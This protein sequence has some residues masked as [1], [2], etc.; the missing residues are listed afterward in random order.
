MNRSARRRVRQTRFANIVIIT[1][2]IIISVD[3]VCEVEQIE[4]VSTHAARSILRPLYGSTNWTAIIRRTIV[5]AIIGYRVSA[6][7]ERHYFVY[8][9]PCEE[10]KTGLRSVH[11]FRTTLHAWYLLINRNF[12][13]KVFVFTDKRAF[14]FTR[15]IRGLSVDIVGEIIWYNK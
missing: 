2:I 6:K 1:I 11:V 9:K 10:N 13:T 5:A 15:K 12:D 7:T 3:L 14:L 8:G 4:N